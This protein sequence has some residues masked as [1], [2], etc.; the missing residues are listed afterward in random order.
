[1]SGAG[2]A[3]DADARPCLFGADVGVI[4]SARPLRDQQSKVKSSSAAAAA[5]AATSTAR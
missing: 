2:R 3:D 5:A 1:M 4:T